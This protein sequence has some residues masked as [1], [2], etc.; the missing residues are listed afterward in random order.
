MIGRLLPLAR[1]LGPHR[2]L[3]IAAIGSGIAHHLVVLASAGVGAWVVSRAITGASPDDLRGG[4]I[5]LGL[6]LPLLAITPWLE[7]YLAH[8]AAFRVLADVRGRVYRAFGRLAPGY[9]LERR[10]GDLGA[11]A[12]SDVEQLELWFAHT[13]SPLV[14]AATVPV[15]ALTALGIFHPT[16]ALALAPALILLAL[17]PA[18]LRRRAEAHGAELRARVGELNAEAV[19]TLQGLRELITSG[20]GDRQLDRLAEQDDRLLAAKLAHGRRSSLEH[21]VTNALTTFGLL[22]VLLTAALL[23]TGQMLDATLFPVAVVLAATTFA[24]VI[25]VT[26]VARD[27]NLVIA[28]GDRIMT[29]LNTPAPVTDRVSEPPPGPIT[30]HVAF[31]GVRFQYGPALPDAVSDISFDIAPSE[32]VALVGHS[33]AGKSTCASL[34]MRMW[35]VNA[36]SITIGGHDIR[37]FPQD[38]LRRLITLVPQDVYLFNIPLIDNIRL[39]RP[40]ASRDDVIAA[41]R[42]AQADEFITGLPDG[43]DTLPGELGARLSGGQ[44]QRIA[45]ARA[46]LKDAPILIMDEAVSNLDTESEQ[47]VAAA[48]TSVRRNRTTLVIAHRLS[49]ILTADRIVVLE[50]GRV[51]DA[52]THQELI[53]RPSAYT[54]LMAA[55]LSGSG[56]A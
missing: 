21:S 30:P 51:A 2:R 17:V 1:L 26:D 53:E 55:Q 29:I 47:E 46:I 19:D 36:G 37:D 23:V 10:S 33:G 48:M 31:S 25:A 12:I 42:A 43:Y 35:D 32:T 54:T 15:A 14:S 4:L 5:V 16:L 49:T 38:D 13:L 39:G 3:L 22:A 8:V 20:A 18:W 50:G 28:A 40:Q 52:G 27:L 24:P 56:R 6:L 44:R 9:L 45:I 41:A 11:A 34:L 7:S